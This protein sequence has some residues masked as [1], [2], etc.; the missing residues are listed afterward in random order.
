MPLS[1]DDFALVAWRLL[2]EGML[3][4]DMYEQLAVRHPD[5]QQSALGALGEAARGAR[6]GLVEEARPVT[7]TPHPGENL[8]I[9]C[10]TLRSMVFAARFYFFGYFWFSH[11]TG[12]REI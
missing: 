5:E 8:P 7:G 1:S 2:G 11:A 9:G 10:A 4:I 3:L 6:H 12:G